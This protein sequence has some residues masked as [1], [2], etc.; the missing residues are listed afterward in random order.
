MGT[1]VGFWRVAWM[2]WVGVV[3]RKN[4][5]EG[6]SPWSVCVGIVGDVAG[7]VCS[8]RVVMVS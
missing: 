1:E 8:Y 7:I 6:G 2:S 4:E 5:S 3:A